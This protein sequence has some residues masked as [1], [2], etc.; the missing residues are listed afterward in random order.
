MYATL[1]IR[2]EGYIDQ[3]CSVSALLIIHSRNFRMLQVYA[4][5]MHLIHSHFMTLGVILSHVQI[6]Y[7]VSIIIL[8]KGLMVTPH[9]DKPLKTYIESTHMQLESIFAID[10][11]C[12]LTG[13]TIPVIWFTAVTWDRLCLDR[14]MCSKRKYLILLRILDG[15]IKYSE[16]AWVY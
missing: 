9:L 16:I 2:F 5:K 12:H 8:V 3:T 10:P 1:N 15:K 4:F 6:G 14:I 11:V 13:V 7:G